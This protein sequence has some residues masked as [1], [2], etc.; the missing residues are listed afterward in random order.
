MHDGVMERESAEK[1]ARR[2][3]F[4]T[5]P[6]GLGLLAAPSRVARL[7]GGGGQIAALRAI[8]A[9]DLALV[10]GLILSRQQSRWM[11]ARVAL[12][13]GI[14]GY[15]VGLVRQNGAV[16]ARVGAGA[17]VLA[18]IDDVRTILALHQPAAA[19]AVGPLEHLAP[20]DADQNL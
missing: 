19:A 10:P 13:L 8:A 17:M 5:L 12:N 6:I 20:R 16:G 7:L 14:A 2:V 9:C 4:I 11:V 1:A 15:C 18:S 3:G